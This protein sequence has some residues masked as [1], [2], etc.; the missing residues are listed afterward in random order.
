MSASATRPAAHRVT[1]F[2]DVLLNPYAFVVMPS[3]LT[4]WTVLS[5]RHPRHRLS[6]REASIRPRNGIDRAS[7]RRADRRQGIRGVARAGQDAPAHE[8][9]SR[10]EIARDASR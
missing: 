3:L 4:L 6:A 10:H 7:C 8:I 9:S 2:I 1:I 5:S